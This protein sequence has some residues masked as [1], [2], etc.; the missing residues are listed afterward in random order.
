MLF[1]SWLLLKTRKFVA[2]TLAEVLITLGIIG[3]VAAMTI[4]TLMTNMAKHATGVK[5][6]KFYSTINQA[7]RLSSIDNGDP[8]SWE[9]PTSAHNYDQDLEYFNTYFAPYLKTSS[10][11]K[12]DLNRNAGSLVCAMLDGG[13]IVINYS[14]GFDIIYLT[15]F[16]YTSNDNTYKQNLLKDTRKAFSFQLGKITGAGMTETSAND[17]VTPYTYGWD[18]TYE[19]LTKRGD[20][21]CSKYCTSR[22]A[23]CTKYLQLNGW[24]FPKDYPWSM[25]ACP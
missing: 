8:G 21:S 17:Y 16:D 19:G 25:K 3:V 14:S 6:E 11:K 5:V 7:V 4:P 13:S 22:P 24:R 9:K 1:G 23:Y 2:F 20:Y 12:V 15:D 18:G 10:C